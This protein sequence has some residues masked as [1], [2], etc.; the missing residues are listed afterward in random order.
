MALLNL[1]PA[2]TATA[3]PS[4]P[5]SNAASSFFTAD[6]KLNT[7]VVAVSKNAD[8]VEAMNR[9]IY[10]ANRLL[11]DAKANPQI[12]EGA[13]INGL[14]LPK[15]LT[16]IAYMLVG[17]PKADNKIE[18]QQMETFAYRL[19]KQSPSLHSRVASVDRSP[20][21]S[22]V[23]PQPNKSVQINASSFFNVGKLNTTEDGSAKVS[24]MLSIALAIVGGD[25]DKC[26]VLT[27]QYTSQ[28][29]PSGWKKMVPDESKPKKVNTVREA[30]VRFAQGLP[31]VI[32]NRSTTKG[33]KAFEAWLK[34]NEKFLDSEFAV[35]F[36]AN[37]A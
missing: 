17:N 36:R 28:T 15:T 30:H 6:G 26:T 9:L 11:N 32:P 5:T 4:Q 7:A 31:S 29:L 2:V 16:Q 3:S 22:L 37:K 8:A 24:D 18:A 12:L 1:L 21:L 34:A 19:F 25:A 14:T 27:H 35:S 20:F 13:T 33:V 23:T 10:A